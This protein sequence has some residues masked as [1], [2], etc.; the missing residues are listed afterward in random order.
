[1][2]WLAGSDLLSLPPARIA[3]MGNAIRLCFGLGLL[4]V[5]CLVTSATILAGGVLLPRARRRQ[6]ARWM[7]F[8]M[9]RLHLGAMRGVGAV[10]LD[11]SALDSLRDAPPMLIAPNH[12]SMVDAALLLSRLPDLTCIMKADILANPLFGSGARMAGYITNDPL[13]SMLRAAAERLRDGH[14]LLLFPEGTRTTHLPVNGLQRTVGAIARL[15][16]V[17]VQTVIIETSSA[18]MGKGW[19]LSRIPRM[20]MDY[21]ARLGRRF[22]PPADTDAFTAELEAYFHHELAGARLPVLPAHDKSR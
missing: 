12:P 1:M 15:A 17:P 22:D 9:F 16:G 6:F 21:T 11:L 14:H 4:A 8:S 20:P 5:M 3:T 10:R 13:R 7:I 2:R 18:F 19:P